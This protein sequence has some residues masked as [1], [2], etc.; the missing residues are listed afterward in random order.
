MPTKQL[1]NRFLGNIYAVPILCDFSLPNCTRSSN[2]TY[3]CVPNPPRHLFLPHKHRRG[4]PSSPAVTLSMAFAIP[5]CILST[6]VH[7]YGFSYMVL[8]IW[9]SSQIILDGL[10]FSI[11][12]RC[13]I[14]TPI[15][16]V[17][18]DGFHSFTRHCVSMTVCNGSTVGKKAI[19]AEK[20]MIIET[21][22]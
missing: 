17:R 2:T 10:F 6:S 3:C 21:L 12:S 20:S 4:S 9:L 18:S 16:F 14:I 8:W 7:I 13:C 5:S 15:L 22:P 19:N 11:P 1:K